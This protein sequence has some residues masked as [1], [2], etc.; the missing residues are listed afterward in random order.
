MPAYIHG[1]LAV[2]QRSENKVK[3][4]EPKKAVN[5]NNKSLPVQ[6]KLLY[7]FTV[8][9]CVVVAGLIIW[10]YAQIYE[11]NTNINKIETKIKQLEAENSVLKH[12][13]D[14]LSSPERLGEEAKKLGLVVP[15]ENQIKPAGNAK[16]GGATSPKQVASNPPSGSSAGKKTKDQP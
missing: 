10:R 11:M 4:K 7:L 8:A 3:P 6:E 9:I 13:V 14:A 5:R 2:E 15:E 12:K 16:S 1:S